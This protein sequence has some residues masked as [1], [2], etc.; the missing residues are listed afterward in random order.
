MKEIEVK[1]KTRAS[2]KD[3]WSA[4]RKKHRQEHGKGSFKQ[5]FVG[6]SQFGGKAAFFEVSN[7]EENKSFTI[8]WKA[9]FVK[10]FFTHT[11]EP[12][13]K[14]TELTYKAQFKGIFA[15][16][17]YWRV[18]KKLRQQ[19]EDSMHQFVYALENKIPFR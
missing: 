3:V 1:V 15:P 7:I 18:G 16:L 14:G 17:V 19:M 11:A 10:L 2:V 12:A 13:T 6:K 5:G 4:W 8:L 9:F